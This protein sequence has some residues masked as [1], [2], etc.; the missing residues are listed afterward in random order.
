MCYICLVHGV[1][2]GQTIVNE[3]MTLR[4][5]KKKRYFL[6]TYQL[7]DSQEEICSMKLIRS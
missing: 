1:L 7:L 5:S 6:L 3:L 4:V 2:Q